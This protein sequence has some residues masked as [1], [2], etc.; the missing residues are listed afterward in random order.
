VSRKLDWSKRNREERVYSNGSIKWNEKEVKKMAYETPPE[1]GGGACY[2]N[3][4]RLS[5]LTTSVAEATSSQGYN[6][7][8]PQMSGSMEV[9]KA[10][11]KMLLEKFKNEETTSSERERT[12]GQPVVKL[13]VGANL[14]VSNNIQK[15]GNP[16]GSYFYFWFRDEWQPPKQETSRPQDDVVLDDDMPF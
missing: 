11:T 15:D 5:N 12:K 14:G 1:Y 6:G 13:D 8:A 3:Q 2:R 4:R 9:T 16:T 10:M 7:K